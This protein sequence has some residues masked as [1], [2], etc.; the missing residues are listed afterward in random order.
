MSI[1][2]ITAYGVFCS[3]PLALAIAINIQQRNV[4]Q[5]MLHLRQEKKS[6]S[7]LK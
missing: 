7:P 3:L 5:A 2:L 6:T 4:E 1:Y